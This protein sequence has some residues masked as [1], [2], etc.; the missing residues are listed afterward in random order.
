[1]VSR[2]S[3]QHVDYS[4]KENWRFW[5]RYVN[6][7]S[8]LIQNSGVQYD[9]DLD[10]EYEDFRQTRYRYIQLALENTTALND[11]FSLKTHL[12]RQFD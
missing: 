4:F 1:M 3:R 8:S 10:G 12:C 5:A 9:I 11:D 7:S 2:K 6:A